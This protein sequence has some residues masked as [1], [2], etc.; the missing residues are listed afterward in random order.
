MNDTFD[1]GPYKTIFT[2]WTDRFLTLLA[3]RGIEHT[4]NAKRLIN[5]ALLSQ[6]EEGPT[7]DLEEIQRWLE[8]FRLDDVATL[9]ATKYNARKLS[10]NRCVRLLSDLHELWIDAR[11][12]GIR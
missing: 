2:N 3:N 5:A 11:H 1:K 9:Y 7:R 10:F 6:V 4:P 8:Q 12:D